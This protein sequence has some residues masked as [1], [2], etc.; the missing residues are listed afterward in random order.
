[1]F[2][3]QQQSDGNLSQGKEPEMDNEN[4]EESAATSP[5][6]A[7]RLSLQSTRQKLHLDIRVLHRCLRSLLFM[8]QFG[9]SY[10]IMLMA[11]YYNGK[12][13]PRLYSRDTNI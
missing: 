4:D 11:M 3:Q 9:I 12:Q 2:Q 13:I 8:L 6:V 10:C 5:L 7:S 1:M